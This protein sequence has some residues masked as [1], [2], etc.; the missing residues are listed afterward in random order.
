MPLFCSAWVSS[1]LSRVTWCKSWIINEKR[2]HEFWKTERRGTWGEKRGGRNNVIIYYNLKKQKKWCLTESRRALP[3][4]M[5]APWW[6]HCW[7]PHGDAIRCSPTS[8]PR[9]FQE[10]WN[11]SIKHK[12]VTHA[13]KSWLK[14]NREQPRVLMTSPGTNHHVRSCVHSYQYLE[15]TLQIEIR[16]LGS[17]ICFL[18]QS[19]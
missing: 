7:W 13:G 8:F 17:I 10:I 6:C 9:T 16:L 19:Y 1:W 15:N 3:P 11:E 2:G 18:K 14:P 5:L 12:L 4:L